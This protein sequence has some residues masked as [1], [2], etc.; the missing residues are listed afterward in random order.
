MGRNPSKNLKYAALGR[1]KTLARAALGGTPR[2]SAAKA[3][4]PVRKIF[5]CWKNG[6]LQFISKTATCTD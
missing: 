1:R 4:E 5:R 6:N 2:N 3:W